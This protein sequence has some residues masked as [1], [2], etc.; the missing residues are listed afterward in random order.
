M[1]RI[2][3]LPWREEL[4][5]ERKKKF[6]TAMGIALG[7]TA[8][9][10]V[11]VHVAEANRIAFEKQRIAFLNQQ[12]KKL[13][14]D[15]AQIQTLETQKKRLQAHM[16]II[17]RLQASRPAVVHL[18]DELARAMPEGVYLTS[19][20]QKGD[21]ITLTGVAQSNAR[22]ST[23]MWNLDKSDWFADPNLT[24]IE[25]IGKEPERVSKFQLRVRQVR[26]GGLAEAGRGEDGRPAARRGKGRS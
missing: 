16:D 3:L 22:V 10:M 9:A 7:I 1:A 26:K 24:V 21:I 11:A 25:T 5:R 23:L 14:E 20:K 12:I 15:I 6:F 4:R 8:A 17:Q 19:L 18:F 2:N 13:D